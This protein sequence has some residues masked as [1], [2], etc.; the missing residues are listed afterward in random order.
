MADFLKPQ[1]SFPGGIHPKND[2]KALSCKTETQVAP[3]L[4]EYR[5]IVHQNA[6]APPK[7]LVK[8]GDLVK[9]G[10]LIA[11]SSG[12]VSANLHAP[13]SG[14]VTEIAQVVNAQGLLVPAVVIASDMADEWTE[15]PPALD[16]READTKIMLERIRSCGIIGM[17]GAAFPSAVKLAPPPGKKIDYL[18]LNGAE[19]EPFLTAD[20]RLMLERPQEIIEGALAMGRV[21]GADVKVRIAVE[22]NKEDAI[23]ALLKAADGLDIG[24]IGMN[25]CY[26][27]GSEKQMIYAATKR[28]VPAGGLP[29]DAGCVV[30][31]VATAQAVYQ[32]L[33]FGRPL[34]ERVVT[35]TGTPIKNPGNWL[36]RIG[37]PFIKLLELCGGIV[38]EPAKIISGGPMMGFAQRTL[39][40]SVVKNTSGLL[41]LT[42]SEVTQ[43]ES[44]ACIRCG[45][46]LDACAMSLRPGPLSMQIES[47][48]FEIVAQNRVMDCLECG[49]CAYV[50]PA[51]RPLVQHMRR[52]KT[53]VRRL[54]AEEK[55]RQEAQK[56]DQ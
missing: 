37:T 3:L 46:C 28:K 7:L 39:N 18:I 54:M 10:Q 30:Q 20:H 6:G 21:L 36:C 5:V 2:G 26:P 47:E 43:Y 31:N 24:I 41:F 48:N 22:T 11:E 1:A 14:K 33:K 16:W 52:G 53:E 17:G 4:P 23:E 32:A 38:H 50:C 42:A 25:V 44:T 29:M 55:A 49:A 56:S 8:A 34:I 35:M 45:R 19:C 12:F 40:S 51:R 27:Q 15:L 9:K 13:T